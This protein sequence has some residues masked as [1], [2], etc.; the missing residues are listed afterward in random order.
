MGG[1]WAVLQHVE[2]EG[3]GLVSAALEEA[4]ERTEVV[5]LDLGE[6]V[7]GP[8]TFDGLVVMGGQM[9]VH[10]TDRFGW[11]EPERRL[12]ADSVEAGIPVLGICLGSQ[13]LAAALGAEVTTGPA[14]EIGIGEVVLTADGRRDPVFGPEY[15]GLGTT[16]VPCV[17]WHRD[18]FAIPTGAA[19][20]A[21]TRAFPHQA[22]RFG[23][24]AYGLQFHVEV[25]RALA[26]AWTALLPEGTVFD[27][28]VLTQVETVGRRILGRFV[29][30]A[31]A[32]R[33]PVGASGD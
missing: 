12:L 29:A 26:G 22:F 17:H 7:P 19:H 24:V 21:A 3:P 11:L 27:R 4:G 25:D 16:S 13:Q 14:A 1:T 8:G 15:N 28:A 33:A 32:R 9:G 30:H 10:D 18:T 23:E 5:R 31:V 2:H 20:L 6:P